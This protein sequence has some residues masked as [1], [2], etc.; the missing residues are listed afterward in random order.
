MRIY[1]MEPSFDHHDRGR[2]GGASR[3]PPATGDIAFLTRAEHRIVAL[4][5]LADRPRDRRALRA[6]S[7]VSPSTICRTL[8]EFEERCW[9]RK[10]GHRYEATQ[11][12]AFV[13]A[14]TMELIDRIETERG[15]RDVWPLLAIGEEDLCIGGLADAVVTVAEA[16]DPYR[17]V[18]RFVSLLRETGRFRF[19]GPELAL[20]EP[21]KDELR[22][23]IVDGMETEIVDPPNAAKH[24]L[25]T[26]SDHCVGPLESGN[27]TVL[28]CDDLPTYGLCLF[29]DRVGISGYDPDSGTVRALIDTDAPAVRE[30][31]ES[32]YGSYRRAARPLTT[33]TAAR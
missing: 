15:L 6:L 28:V 23:R 7:G 4:D 30:W 20:L 22:Q 1:S 2:T 14:G 8:R 31:A 10:D 11:L 18:N 29:D 26:Y 27:L 16:D 33:E 13:A 25:S 19:A 32:I 5:A 21:C 9:V 17:P 3:A 12:G 24:V